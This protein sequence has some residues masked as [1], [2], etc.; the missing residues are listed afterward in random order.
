MHSSENLRFENLQ[1]L[2]S[3]KQSYWN[4]EEFHCTHTKENKKQDNIDYSSSSDYLLFKALLNYLIE[5]R[6]LKV[7]VGKSTDCDL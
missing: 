3:M 6:V 2:E 5:K 1:E 4:E 7:D